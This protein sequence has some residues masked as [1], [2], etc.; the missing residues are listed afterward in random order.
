MSQDIEA[1]T[2][3]SASV[4]TNRKQLLQAYWFSHPGRTNRKDFGWFAPR[5]PMG[6]RY[7]SNNLD[8]TSL[9]SSDT[10]GDFIFS[11]M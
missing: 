10:D 2:Y 7:A 11:L 8:K 5:G 3:F 6:A 9:N 4:P 1:L